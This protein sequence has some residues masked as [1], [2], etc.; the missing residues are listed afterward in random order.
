MHITIIC[1]NHMLT[2]HHRRPSTASQPADNG[3]NSTLTLAF[4]GSFTRSQLTTART[5]RTHRTHRQ[6]NQSALIRDL[7]YYLRIL[8]ISSVVC[9][10]VSGF[11]VSQTTIIE[12]VRPLDD[13]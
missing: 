6:R 13:T 4:T 12:Y 3:I 8:S 9:D 1:P 7:R 11:M 5:H 2:T 10:R